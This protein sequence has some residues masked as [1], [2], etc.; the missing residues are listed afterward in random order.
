MNIQYI[1]DQEM[2]PFIGFEF[3]TIFFI[4]TIFHNIPI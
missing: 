2:A 4:K 3:A 1:I